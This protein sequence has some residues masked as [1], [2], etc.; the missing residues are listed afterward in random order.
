MFVLADKPTVHSGGVCRRR[1]CGFYLFRIVV[2]VRT[3]HKT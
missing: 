3:G 1:V 2:T